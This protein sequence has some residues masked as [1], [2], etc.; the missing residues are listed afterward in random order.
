MIPFE[1]KRPCKT[2]P[3]RTDETGLR[4]LGTERATEIVEACAEHGESFTCHSDLSKPEAKR[5]QCVGMMLMLHKTNQH[6]QIMQVAERLGVFD[7][8]SLQG[9]RMCGRISVLNEVAADAKRYRFIRDKMSVES[10]LGSWCLFDS[11]YKG[12]TFNE[13]IDK[14]MERMGYE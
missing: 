14:E 8:D 5:N 7:P 12:D 1:R 2:C 11:A 4:H 9:C 13:A 6:N 10:S 3:F